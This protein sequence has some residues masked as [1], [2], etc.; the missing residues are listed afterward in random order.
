MG[1]SYKF[2]GISSD[3]SQNYHFLTLD[4][5]EA[6]A[7]QQTLK[8]AL[9]TRDPWDREV[10]FQ[11]KK[12]LAR[13]YDAYYEDKAY[14]VNNFV[15]YSESK[16]VENLLWMQ[17][18]YA[19]ISS[20]KQRIASLD[21]IVQ[22]SPRNQP[23][24]G[25]HGP[26]EYRKLMQRFRQF[27]AEEERFWSKLI[28]RLQRAFGL[29]EAHAAIVLLGIAANDIPV[30]TNDDH[31]P[32]RTTNGRNHW[33][34][35][36]EEPSPAQSAAERAGRMA[37]LSKALVCLGDIARYRELYNESNGRPKAGHDEPP[38]PPPKRGGRNRNFGAGTVRARNYDKAQQCYEQ[39]RL[40]VPYEGNP[41]HQLAILASYQ[42]DL[43]GSLVHYYRALCV[44]QPYDTASDNLGVV[45]NK[46]LD[47][48]KN[49]I[50]RLKDKA[51]D[52]ERESGV[53]APH[54][55]VEIFKER[56]VVLHALWRLG[57][58]RMDSASPKH[59]DDVLEDFSSLLADRVL[60]IDLIS[61]VVILSH[62]ALWK[63]RTIRDP[64]TPAA[65]AA[66]IEARITTHILS[67][68]RVLLEVGLVQLG[69]SPPQDA[70][71]NDLAQQITATFRRMLPALRI[72]SKW[73]RANFKYVQASADKLEAE[74]RGLC[75]IISDLP[76][77]WTSYA[78]FTSTLYRLF[79]VNRLP[80][81]VSPLEEDVD[82][83]GFLPLKKLM[84]GEGHESSKA[85]AQVHPNEEQL[86]R[87]A[88]LLSDADALVRLENSPLALR[89]TSQAQYPGVIY[90]GA[91]R[92]ITP[93]AHNI[94]SHVMD[95]RIGQHQMTDREE[96][97]MTEISRDD[98][99]GDAFRKALGSDR[100]ESDDD[101]GNDM[102]VWNPR[103]SASP[104]IPSAI[105]LMVSSPPRAI[106]MS[107]VAPAFVP[108]S[109]AVQSP[110]KPGA[111]SPQALKT[112]V[113][114]IPTHTTAQDLVNSIMNGPR[115]AD[116]SSNILHPSGPQS[117]APQPKFLFGSEPPNVPGHS[118]WS[119][120]LDNNLNNFSSPNPGFPSPPS[121]DTPNQ[122]FARSP[123]RLSQSPWPSS[124]EPEP[125]SQQRMGRP[126]LPD[127][128]PHS[129]Q[130]NS[131]AHRHVPPT[132][133][134]S[135]SSSQQSNSLGY[136]LDSPQQPFNQPSHGFGRA[137]FTDPAIMGSSALQSNTAFAGYDNN[138]V[139]HDLRMGQFGPVAIPQ[140]WGN[141]G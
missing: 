104:I 134:Y 128:A 1:L 57:V 98:P 114:I 11:R 70:A 141:N 108:R 71:E 123:Q 110:I 83:R 138:P 48:W 59:A 53:V 68:H 95:R 16:D 126:F 7:T 131:L 46:A 78:A 30:A 90:V 81:L 94:L 56:V 122:P 51:A 58:D 27:L 3:N 13:R 63:H 47:Q 118:I 102:I 29:N 105:P 36:L 26:V 2:L 117:T 17:T 125:S 50:K 136:A 111:R 115:L 15:Y 20:Y 62:G 74:K 22:S 34:F 121:F 65:S 84:V 39:A 8:E 107:P 21:R 12:I 43:F 127:L 60:P 113:T 109:P 93:P 37:I 41:S 77:F 64:T 44:L 140:L 61:K 23:R 88:D 67:I 120:S 32:Q 135:N 86:M 137:P 132:N 119:L 72:A 6:K 101:D 97:V 49:R 80:A 82:M 42:K 5:R 112:A 66:H 35:P 129:P 31:S 25:G 10:E 130:I 24:Q 19:F 52:R 87:I 116:S 103:A 28:E 96:D 99:V 139:H 91:E 124:Y 73:L 38:P 89:D 18:S 14:G 33:Q 76:S 54:L 133:L 9:K 4:R 69:E 55:R 85:I 100:M 45:L 92:H 79:P 40:L 75:V 106:P